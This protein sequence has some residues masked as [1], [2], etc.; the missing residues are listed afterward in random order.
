MKKLVI[1][2]LV[3]L[4]LSTAAWAHRGPDFEGMIEKWNLSEQ[5]SN[6]LKALMEK[7]RE[8]R[9]ALWEQ[10]REAMKALREQ[11]RQ[12]LSKVLSTEQMKELQDQVK[13]FRSKREHHGRHGG[14][15][16][17]EERCEADSK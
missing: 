8:A 11:Q 2:T 1:A 17:W 4:S 3:A 13:A 10:Q 6:E 15:G 7:H 16:R 9:K 14:H 5:Q 12:D